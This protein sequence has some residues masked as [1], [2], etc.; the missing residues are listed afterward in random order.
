MNGRDLCL[1]QAYELSG[2]CELG[3]N[4]PNSLHCKNFHWKTL[5]WPY[6]WNANAF[7]LNFHL[8][9]QS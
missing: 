2:A 1:E 5:L 9:R 4:Y 6:L 7:S 8:V 3:S